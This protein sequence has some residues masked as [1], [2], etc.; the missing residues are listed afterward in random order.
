MASATHR[1]G[2][3]TTRD[4]TPSG[5]DKVAGDVVILSDNR[6]GVVVADVADGV[7]GAVYIDGVFDIT[8][9]SGTTFSAG[10]AVSLDVSADNVIVSTTAAGDV[11]AGVALAAKTSGQLVATVDLN[12][13]V[14]TVAS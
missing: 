11:L 4:Y 1:Y 6:V 12:A 2:A 9:A 8:S 14:G 13:R 3:R 5:A 7:Q 10:A